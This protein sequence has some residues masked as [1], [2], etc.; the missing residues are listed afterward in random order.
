MYVPAGATVPCAAAAQQASRVHLP[1]PV[2]AALALR[3]RSSGSAHPIGETA[4]FAANRKT[5][6]RQAPGIADELMLPMHGVTV[7]W[8]ECP[9]SSNDA[10]E[11][12]H[13]DS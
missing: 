6:A 13:H 8:C 11:L 12:S 4:V 7:L 3:Q 9:S 10:S 1:H 2:R 5:G